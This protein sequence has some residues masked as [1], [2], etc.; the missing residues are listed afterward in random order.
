MLDSLRAQIVNSPARFTGFELFH[1]NAIRNDDA[2]RL[3]LKLLRFRA[4][5]RYIEYQYY[6]RQDE[7]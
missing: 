7:Q 4:T 5:I 2:S 6:R 3:P 1:H